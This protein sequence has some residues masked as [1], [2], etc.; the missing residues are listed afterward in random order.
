[1]S[2]TKDLSEYLAA[3]ADVHSIIGSGDHA[4]IFDS[5]ARESVPMPLIVVDES[6]GASSEHLSGTSGLAQGTYMITCYGLTV[7]EAEDL[8]ERVR[9]NLQTFGPAEMNAPQ[10]TWVHGVHMTAYRDRGYHQ[11]QDASQR[12][13]YYLASTYDIWH[14]IPLEKV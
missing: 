12:W 7:P 2:M 14:N 3:Q 1:M 9:V 13:I 6:G 10:G 8:W 11:P 5:I 4:K